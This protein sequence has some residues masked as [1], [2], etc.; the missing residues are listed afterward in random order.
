MQRIEVNGIRYRAVTRLQELP[1]GT[2]IVIEIDDF[3]DVA[4]FH[5]SDG[6]FAVS[7]ICPHQHSPSIGAGYVKDCTVAC[8]LHGWTFDLKTGK[9]LEPLGGAELTTYS[10]LTKDSVVYLEEREPEI[11]KWM[12]S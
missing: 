5:T 8:P 3:T 10:V 6:L 4:L 2:S 7:N 1:L 9:L 12:R 11:P